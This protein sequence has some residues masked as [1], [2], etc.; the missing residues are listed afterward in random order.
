MNIVGLGEKLLLKLINENMVSNCADIYK[1][2]MDELAKL[3]RMGEKS[4]A[5]IIQSIENSKTRG[6]DKLIYALGI[7]EVG[8]KAAKS[9]AVQLRDIENFFISNEEELIEVEDI[10]E[11]TAH[12]VIEYF[13]NPETRVIIDELKSY[14]VL[15]VIENS[16]S[17]QPDTFSG[18]TFVLTGTLPTLTRSEAQALI[19]SR[20]GKTASSVSKKTD[21]LLAEAIREVNTQKLNHSEL[22]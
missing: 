3:D 4:A 10:G 16:D 21:Y 2:K 22:R 13:K 18:M 1:L 11:I 5:N 20:G 8:E 17:G 7:R 9:L 15:T 12:N 19:E 14:G 6:L